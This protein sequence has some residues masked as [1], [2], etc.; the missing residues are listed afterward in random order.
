MQQHPAK[1]RELLKPPF[2]GLELALG[3]L[4]LL[5]VVGAAVVYVGPDPSTRDRVVA[6]ILSL[7]TFGFVIAGA[8][9]VV[10]RGRAHHRGDR[11][12]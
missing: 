9:H 5:C 6:V 10:H 7:L 8:L 12:E 4:G 1:K 11:P 2:T 3:A